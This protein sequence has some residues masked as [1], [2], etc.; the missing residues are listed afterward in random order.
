MA[1]KKSGRKKTKQS[2]EEKKSAVS[3]AEEEDPRA[4]SAFQ[5]GQISRF[6]ERRW[7]YPAMNPI[8]SLFPWR[9][10]RPWRESFFFDRRKNILSELREYEG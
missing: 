3:E 9:S 7:Q 10:W 6:S 4:H 1:L 5:T 2:E 8:L